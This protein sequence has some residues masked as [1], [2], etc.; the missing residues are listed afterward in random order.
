[1]ALNHVIVLIGVVVAAML[2]GAVIRVFNRFIAARNACRNARSGIDVK[3]TK[4]H[5]LPLSM[6]S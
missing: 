6:L 2:A 4:R 3:L 1:M 5:D